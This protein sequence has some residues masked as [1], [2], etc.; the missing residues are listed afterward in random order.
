MAS[1]GDLR[2]RSL[3]LALAMTFGVGA[4]LSLDLAW[5][6]KRH[7]P[8]RVVKDSDST[9]LK[10]AVEAWATGKRREDEGDCPQYEDIFDAKESSVDDGAFVVEIP[11]EKNLYNTVY[12]EIGYHAM[13]YT[14]IINDEDGSPVS[15][16]T[17][18]MIKQSMTDQEREEEV[19]RFGIKTTYLTALYLN[20]LANLRRIN[21]DAVDDA[22]REYG[23]MVSQ[24]D[25]R[26]GEL[27][28]S[29]GDIVVGWS[30]LP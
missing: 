9:P 2:F 28:F 29:L 7:H 21:P 6:E 14:K 17:V 8:G 5:G 25:E 15:P 23:E 11:D 18:R 4:I 30:E 26:A 13:T 20:E 27:V 1:R 22:L 24:T 10:V 12:C 3:A 19:Q 16:Y